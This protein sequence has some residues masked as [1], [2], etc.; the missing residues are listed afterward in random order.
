MHSQAHLRL[1]SSRGTKS[2]SGS[3]CPL[4]AKSMS[5][6]PLLPPLLLPLVSPPPGV[7]C[8]SVRCSAPASRALLSSKFSAV[9]SPCTQVGNLLM[10]AV[11]LLQP[12][13]LLPPQVPAGLPSAALPFAGWLAAPSVT[14]LQQAQLPC[15]TSTA[16]SA[17]R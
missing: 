17:G 9:R 14:A 1:R 13:Q 5:V 12:P 15:P 6:T 3:P 10:H 7:G 4:S 8:W 11:A 16:G 2:H